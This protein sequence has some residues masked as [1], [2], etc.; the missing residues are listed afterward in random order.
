MK[1]FAAGLLIVLFGMIG[2]RIVWAQ[3]GQSTRDGNTQFQF[4]AGDLISDWGRPS[5]KVQTSRKILVT[6]P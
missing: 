6:A 3:K 2:G 5:G 4:K 1:Q